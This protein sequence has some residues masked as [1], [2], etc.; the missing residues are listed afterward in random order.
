MIYYCKLNALSSELRK[1]L[2]EQ[3][4]KSFSFDERL[5]LVKIM[6]DPG[7]TTNINYVTRTVQAT[8][9]LILSIEDDIKEV[10][11]MIR[12]RVTDQSDQTEL[13]Q[14]L[15]LERTQLQVIYSL[16]YL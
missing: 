14:L 1:S 2:I 15:E 10:R 9:D 16:K 5:E 7:F 13:I 8:K 12:H 11:T 3:L 4:K 6:I